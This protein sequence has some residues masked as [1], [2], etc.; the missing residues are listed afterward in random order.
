MHD[1][2]ASESWHLRVAT[3]AFFL[4]QRA[5]DQQGSALFDSR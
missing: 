4:F 1:V 3:G 5:T 2:H